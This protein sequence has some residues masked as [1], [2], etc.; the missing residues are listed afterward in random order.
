L[1]PLNSL[2]NK[3]S[4]SFSVTYIAIPDV[5]LFIGY[6]GIFGEI[7][8]LTL[9]LFWLTSKGYFKL[10]IWIFGYSL[11]YIFIIL[12]VYFKMFTPTDLKA[13]LENYSSGTVYTVWYLFVLYYSFATLLQ[14][15]TLHYYRKAIFKKKH[16]YK[17]SNL[18]KT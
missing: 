12:F 4:P 13:M 5:S 16:Q 6:A 11:S 3:E 14:I 7:A 1:I 18:R 2:I 8:V 10:A 9:M 15:V 17:F